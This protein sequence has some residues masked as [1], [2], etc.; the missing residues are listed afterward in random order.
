[1][2]DM[3]NI[4][5]TL[6]NTP[7]LDEVRKTLREKILITPQTSEEMSQTVRRQEALV[8]S[9]LR[10]YTM[11]DNGIP[12]RPTLRSLNLSNSVAITVYE[13]L[14]QLDFPEMQGSGSM[15]DQTGGSNK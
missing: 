14:R 15:L 13:A 9:L 3:Q 1:M 11:Y 10:A 4:R 12:M 6:L 8:D 5:S 2:E 7:G